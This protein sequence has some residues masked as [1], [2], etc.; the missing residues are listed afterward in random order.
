MSVK[1]TR[2]IFSQLG[3]SLVEV[4]VA[5]GIMAGLAG[6]FG[7]SYVKLGQSKNKSEFV[8]KLTALESAIN[9]ALLDSTTYSANM[10]SFRDGIIPAGF[11]INGVSFSVGGRS[12]S[13]DLPVNAVT[14]FGPNFEAC[15][16][17]ACRFEVR[18]VMRS[19]S[20]ARSTGVSENSVAANYS[21]KVINSDFNIKFVGGGS[22]KLASEAFTD[23]DLNIVVPDE[24]FE[25]ASALTRLCDF[26]N[27]EYIRGYNRE[28]GEA[29]C[30]VIPSLGATT[31]C[32]ATQIPIGVEFDATANL[33]RFRCR[34]LVN[35]QCP[36]NDAATGRF[37]SLQTITPNFLD[38]LATPPVGANSRPVRGTCVIATEN[39]SN[40]PPPRVGDTFANLHEI[41][42]V[43]CSPGYRSASSCSIDASS[44]VA[45]NGT[46]GDCATECRVWDYAPPINIEGPPGVF[47]P[48]SYPFCAAYGVTVPPVPGVVSFSQSGASVDCRLLFQPQQ[49]GAT[50]TARLNLDVTCVWDGTHPETISAEDL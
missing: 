17:A 50:W 33:F 42:G 8:A 3:Y 13:L 22:Q 47:T 25:T 11:T 26:Q 29:N 40:L 20:S 15:A 7:T 36:V 31:P 43:V 2:Q 14:N 12:F 9:R 45:T 5:A 27:G 6:V 41:R 28:T 46:T 44:I 37:Y 16:G 1:T 18:V 35:A 32:S 49:C 24:L 4:L 39:T 10:N 19:V 48:T 21:L 38:S 23:Q 34:S 30:S